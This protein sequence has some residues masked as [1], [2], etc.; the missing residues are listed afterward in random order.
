MSGDRRRRA[1]AADTL[2]RRDPGG[3]LYGAVVTAGVLAA[4]SANISHVHRVALGVASVLVAY[5]LAHV[6]VASQEMLFEGD[7]GPLHRRIRSAAAE[8]ITILVGGVPAVVVYLA[9]HF[10]ADLTASNAAFVA[11]WFSVAFLFV[12]GYLGAHRAGITGWRLAV[13]SLGA[14]SLGAL[15][16]VGKLLMH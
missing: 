11:L 4:I 10:V 6:Y 12:I 1:R 9:A 15:A 14:A 16:V 8:E 5:W 2:A 3:V 7:H 13:E